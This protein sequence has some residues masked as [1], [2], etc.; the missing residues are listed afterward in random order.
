MRFSPYLNALCFG[1]LTGIKGGN[2]KRKVEKNMQ[3]IQVVNGT[4]EGD[5]L[6]RVGTTRRVGFISEGI[7]YIGRKNHY[8]RLKQ[9]PLANPYHIGKDGERS[10]VVQKYRFWL[11]MEVTKGLKGEY[12]PAFSEL[13]CIRD[14]VVGGEKIKLARRE[15]PSTMSWRCC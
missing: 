11:D 9:S 6:G 2:F 14:K 10:T 12:S 13:K 1:V 15:R 7:I 4:K 8:Y 5:K 3:T